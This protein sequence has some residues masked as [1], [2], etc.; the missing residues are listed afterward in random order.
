MSKK[1]L[2]AARSPDGLGIFKDHETDWVLKRT[3]EQMSE[4]AAETGELLFAAHQIEE[5]DGESWISVWA[6]LGDRILSHAQEALDAGHSVSAREAFLRA[7]NYYRTAEYGC[8]PQ[9]PRFHELWSK[10]VAAFQA[11]C[12]LFDPPIQILNIPFD[13]WNLPGYFWQPKNDG[14]KRPTFISL[15]GNDSSGEEIFI[16]TGFGAVRRGY[17]YFT[18]EYPGHRGAVHLDNNCVKRYDYEVPVKASLDFLETLPG[19][20]DR[21][22]LGGFSYGGY[23]ASR[24]ACFEK[25]IKAVL[26]DTPIVDMPTLVLSGFLGPLIK[27]LSPDILD[28]VVARRL[29]KSPLTKAL[30]DYSAWTW[31]AKSLSEEF[32]LDSFR[33]HV[34]RDEIKAIDCPALALVGKDEGEEMVKQA[35]FF[36][37][38]ISS[39]NKHI[40]TFTRERDGS[41]DHCQMDNFSRAHQVAFD[42]LDDIFPR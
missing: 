4:K 6:N 16:T 5:T 2:G 24:V 15:G 8:P 30:L 28:R 13:K 9:H 22:A 35:H 3:W 19:V 1:Y 29:R 23:V 36:Y 38:N 41:N 32:A 7:S 42:W 34:I 21:I 31:G 26:P 20:D 25:R 11:A 17:N 37:D 10:S 33:N 18:F 39:T 12:P 14:R 27:G 40:H